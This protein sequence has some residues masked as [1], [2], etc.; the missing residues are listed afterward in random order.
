MKWVEDEPKWNKHHQNEVTYPDHPDLEQALC[1][2][3]EQN[4]RYQQQQKY[5]TKGVD[6]EAVTDAWTIFLRLKK[7]HGFF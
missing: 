3:R 4:M 2:F 6:T 1:H 7:K 5:R